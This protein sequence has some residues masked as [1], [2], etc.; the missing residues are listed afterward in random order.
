MHTRSQRSSSNG[1][2]LAAS[3]GATVLIFVG[4][5]H[6]NSNLLAQ[7]GARENRIT[8][9]EPVARPDNKVTTHTRVKARPTR[10]P[11]RQTSN[12]TISLWIVSNPPGCKVTINGEP[13]GETDANGELELKLE[14]GTHRIR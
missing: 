7:G 10:K 8:P 2:R 12:S 13:Q 4:G 6:R 3:V 14:P 9:Q 5:F 11:L 1:L